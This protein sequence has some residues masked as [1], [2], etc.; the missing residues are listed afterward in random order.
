MKKTGLL[1]IALLAFAT[2]CRRK[3]NVEIVGESYAQPTTQ[4][5]SSTK[6]LFVDD[7]EAFVLEDETDPFSTE[8]FS[9]QAGVTLVPVEEKSQ[10]QIV[11]KTIYFDFGLDGLRKDQMPIIEANL[12]KAKEAAAKGLTVVIEGHACKFAGSDTYNMMLSEKRAKAVAQYFIKHG[13]AKDRIKVVGRGNEMCI[14]PEG[15]KDAQAPNRR[16]EIYILK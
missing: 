6:S 2:G 16:V 11:F 15:D 9:A 13:V 10:S 8:G 7:V 1:L 14:I 3:K 5:S 12:E 4:A